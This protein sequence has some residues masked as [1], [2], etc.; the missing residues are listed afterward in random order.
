M[1]CR[2]PPAN[3]KFG[4]SYLHRNKTYVYKVIRAYGGR[5]VVLFS[6]RVVPAPVAW[7]LLVP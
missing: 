4:I 3:N 7:R 1:A 2:C 6:V 5:F